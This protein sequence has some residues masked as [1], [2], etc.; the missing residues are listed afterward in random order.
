[1]NYDEYAAR[2]FLAGIAAEVDRP[3]L[4]ASLD[5]NGLDVSAVP[6]QIGRRMDLAASM[7]PLE[8]KLRS[9]TDGLF[10]LVIEETTPAI[11]D[12][13]AAALQAR[14]VLSAP[15]VLSVPEAAEGDPGPWKVEPQQLAQLLVIERVEGTGGGSIQVRLDTEKLRPFLADAAQ[16]LARSP[17]NA[18]FNL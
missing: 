2:A 15:L 17:A 3:V 7:V 5:I 1:M 13:E 10:A 18:R 6:G 11:L 8:E 9:M 4:E 12:A 14:Q 16:S